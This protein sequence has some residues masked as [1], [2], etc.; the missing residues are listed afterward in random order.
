M[1]HDIKQLPS[2]LNIANVDDITA[3]QGAQYWR[4]FMTWFIVGCNETY[5]FYHMG[6][7]YIVCPTGYYGDASLNYICTSC[8]APCASCSNSLTNCTSCQILW[9]TLRVRLAQVDNITNQWSCVCSEGY[10]GDPTV[11]CTLCSND[12]PNCLNCKDASLCT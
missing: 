4:F 12:I 11:S 8:S 2:G 7:C 6:R 5:P 10:Y 3:T 9:L 1:L